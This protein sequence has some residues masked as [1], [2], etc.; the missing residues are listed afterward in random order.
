LTEIQDEQKHPAENQ[1]ELTNELEEDA[2]DSKS[3]EM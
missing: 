1:D 3:N 2:S